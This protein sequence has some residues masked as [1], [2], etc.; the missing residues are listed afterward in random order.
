M[1]VVVLEDEPA[2]V[3]HVVGGADHAADQ[4]NDL[5]LNDGAEV[6]RFFYYFFLVKF[7]IAGKKN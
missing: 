4:I 5:I 2:L 1:C 6:G 7:R 3:V